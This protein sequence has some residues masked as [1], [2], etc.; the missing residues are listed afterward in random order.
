MLGFGGRTEVKWGVRKVVVSRTVGDEDEEG[1]GPQ[2]IVVM[3]RTIGDV[4]LP[5][6]LGSK[7]HLRLC[8][9]LR[10]TP[11]YSASPPSL[12]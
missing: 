5:Y 8:S 4:S 7:M 1:D 9:R 3:E 11:S 6:T 2:V 10:P 12:V